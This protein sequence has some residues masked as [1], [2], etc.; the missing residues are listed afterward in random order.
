MNDVSWDDAIPEKVLECLKFGF[1]SIMSVDTWPEK[2][3]YAEFYFKCR[4]FSSDVRT[5][6]IFKNQRIRE[7]VYYNDIRVPPNIVDEKEYIK[8]VYEI[9]KE[10][11]SE[12]NNNMLDY[13]SEVGAIERIMDN[14]GM[15]Y[16]D[17]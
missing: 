7:L 16:G 5:D 12:A 1:R 2:L 9:T 13:S 3:T 14:L 11:L 8:Y 17:G 4:E 15:E 6:I 10:L